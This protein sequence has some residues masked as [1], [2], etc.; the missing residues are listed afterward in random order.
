MISRTGSLI[1]QLPG[2]SSAKAPCHSAEKRRSC[3]SSENVIVKVLSLGW[4]RSYSDSVSIYEYFA[5]IYDARNQMEAELLAD[6]KTDIRQI[7]HGGLPDTVMEYSKMCVPVFKK[8]GERLFLLLGETGDPKFGTKLQDVFIHN[9]LD[10]SHLSIE[11]PNRDYVMRFL[12]AGGVSMLQL[13]HEKGMDLS[14]RELITL[15]QQLLAT[16]VEGYLHLPIFR[17]EMPK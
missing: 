14:E 9:F 16:G 2:E 11:I 17:G 5:D 6:I 8:Y 15:C 10:I 3:A 4:R 13:W 7:F 1:S 12:Y